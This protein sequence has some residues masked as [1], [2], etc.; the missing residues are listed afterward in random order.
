MLQTYWKGSGGR[1]RSILPCHQVETVWVHRETEVLNDYSRWSGRELQFDG[2]GHY[3]LHVTNVNGPAQVPFLH[4]LLVCSYL[5][6]NH[7]F[8]SELMVGRRIGNFFPCFFFMTSVAN[9]VWFEVNFMGRRWGIY[10]RAHE[11]GAAP[12]IWFNCMRQQWSRYWT[13]KAIV[14]NWN[15]LYLLN[16]HLCFPAVP[17]SKLYKSLS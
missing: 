2:V 7:F 13:S 12:R 9:L 8:F 4:D 1:A 10:I 14:S 16:K 5:S 17:V 6:I 15:N 11:L 3:Y